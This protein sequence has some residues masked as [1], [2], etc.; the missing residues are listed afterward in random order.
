MTNNIIILQER[1]RLLAAGKIPHTGRGMKVKVGDEVKVFWEPIE[2]HTF[3]A[4]KERGYIV[5]KG[6][7]AISKLTIWIPCKG[8]K[9]DD[10]E[11]PEADGEKPG[12]KMRMKKAFFFS[13]LQ[14]VPIE[15][16][17]QAAEPVT[18]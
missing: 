15:Q 4:W 13:A 12:V 16:T 9:G 14:V 11:N 18:V 1:F 7:H 17:E 5:K 8:K 10:A 3:A 2:I 6:E